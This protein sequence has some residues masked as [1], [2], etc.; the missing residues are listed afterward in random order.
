MPSRVAVQ[1]LISPSLPDA[2]SVSP[3]GRERDVAQHVGP[4]IEVAQSWPLASAPEAGGA[5]AGGRPPPA[6]HPA[7]TPPNGSA[8]YGRR[9]SGLS[10]RSGHPRSGPIS[11]ASKAPASRAGHRAKY[12]SAGPARSMPVMRRAGRPVARS[13][14]TIARS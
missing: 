8:G 3:V 4:A 5:V 11:H 7:R 6:V 1:S 2:T 9:S 14:M 13:Q 12:A 10:A